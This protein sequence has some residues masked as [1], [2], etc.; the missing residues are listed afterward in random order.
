MI[1]SPRHL[2]A[3]RSDRQQHTDG[4]TWYQAG[5]TMALWTLATAVATVFKIVVDSTKPALGMPVAQRDIAPSIALASASVTGQSADQ[6]DLV[7]HKRHLG[8]TLGGLKQRPRDVARRRVVTDQARLATSCAPPNAGPMSQQPRI[9]VVDAASGV[10]GVT[11]LCLSH[12]VRT[13]T[14]ISRQRNLL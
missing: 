9:S 12:C 3:L 6:D 11:A 13:S 1:A 2:P 8:S 5:A 14:R 7:L 4:T 10:G